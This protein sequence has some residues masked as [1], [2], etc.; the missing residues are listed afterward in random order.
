MNLSWRGLFVLLPKRFGWLHLGLFR[1]V[2]H[3]T[4]FGTTLSK[5]C[6]PAIACSFVDHK[7]FWIYFPISPND[8]ENLKVLPTYRQQSTVLTAPTAIYRHAVYVLII[9]SNDDCIMI[10]FLLGNVDTLDMLFSNLLCNIMLMSWFKVNTYFYFLRNL[11]QKLYMIF[12]SFNSNE[13]IY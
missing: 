5:P 2:S 10:C 8:N 1:M 4:I 12:C 7:A 3:Q 9:R 13:S 11:K 6:S